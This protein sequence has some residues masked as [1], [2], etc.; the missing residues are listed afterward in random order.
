[1]PQ[2]LLIATRNRHNTGEIAAM[3]GESYWVTDLKGNTVFP[4]V[5]ETGATFI[6]NAV[7]KAVQISAHALRLNPEDDTY[8]LA[9]DS[10]LEVDALG[11]APGVR[12][13]RYAGE[14]AT[15]AE[16]LALLLHNLNCVTDLAAR[17]GRFRCAMALARRGEVVATFEGACE[18]RLIFEARGEHG[19]GYDPVFIPEGE[20]LTFA[21]LSPEVKNRMSHR[22]RALMHAVSWLRERR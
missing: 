12:S 1:M 21:E 16:N 13:A 20:K 8:V 2:P 3:L 6:E 11:G 15:D 5:E 4:E 22:A 18:G 10:G 7:L 19:F 9:D 17:T 14:Q